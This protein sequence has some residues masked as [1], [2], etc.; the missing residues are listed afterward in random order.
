M[1]PQQTIA[2]IEIAVDTKLPSYLRA[3]YCSDSA[4]TTLFW[5]DLATEAEGLP[6]C[7]TC[8]GGSAA[9]QNRTTSVRFMAGL[10]LKI[11]K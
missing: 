10:G 5:V 3:K 6:P 2:P 11:E 8:E 1:L 9:A 7:A 4:V